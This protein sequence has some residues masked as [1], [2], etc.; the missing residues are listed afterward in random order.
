M[1]G[2][3]LEIREEDF[4]PDLT[5]SNLAHVIRQQL[6]LAQH[7]MATEIDAWGNL[8]GMHLIRRYSNLPC[9]AVEYGVERLSKMQRR[10]A[11]DFMQEHL[12]TNVGLRDIARALGMTQY[13][14]ARAFRNATGVSVHQSLVDMRINRARDLL[15]RTE[16][17]LAEIAYAC[18]FSSQ[19]HMTSWFRRKHG[20]T[21]NQFRHSV[22]A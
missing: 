8:I 7:P 1:D 4:V 16:R 15:S 18:G 17:P 21:P 14:F 10:R 3:E 20:V 22:D 19:S 6:L 12:D 11:I 5:M 2:N 9:R 13:R